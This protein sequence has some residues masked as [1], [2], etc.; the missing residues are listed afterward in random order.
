M[1]ITYFIH[2]RTRKHVKYWSWGEKKGHLNLISATHLK[3]LE[4]SLQ[5]LTKACKHLGT[6]ET[7][8]WNSSTVPGLLGWIFDAPDVFR[9]WEVC[10]AGRP[11]QHLDYSSIKPCSS[12]FTTIFLKTMQGLTWKRN[13]RWNIQ[14]RGALVPMEYGYH[15]TP[16]E[17]QALQKKQDGLSHL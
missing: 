2:N 16:S 14:Y 12:W 11:V 8:F 17:M 9:W 7:S 3:K 13:L 5:L 15:I 1:Q 6:E 10:A 4:Q